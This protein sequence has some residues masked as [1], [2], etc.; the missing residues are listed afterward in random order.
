MRG[1][2]SRPCAPQPTRAH[3]CTPV[4]RCVRPP[5]ARPGCGRWRGFHW[6]VWWGPVQT[7]N[8][9]KSKRRLQSGSGLPGSPLEAPLCASGSAGRGS[10]RKGL[11]GRTREAPGGS[12]QTSHSPL[13][14]SGRA[15]PGRAPCP[16]PPS[17][18]RGEWAPDGERAGQVSGGGGG[19]KAAFGGS[20]KAGP[21]WRAPRERS[22]P[23]LEEPGRPPRSF[24]RSSCRHGPVRPQWP[25]LWVCL[26]PPGW[27]K[28]LGA[29]EGG[30]GPA[31]FCG[32]C[33][34]CPQGAPI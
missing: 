12:T 29:W 7:A 20:V 33:P 32:R 22:A 10:G 15:E 6:R 27:L 26:P 21:G 25:R 18:S 24:L 19:T 9:M 3:L 11:C 23:P 4:V 30:L 8:R 5:L 13:L 1:Q 28:V 17:L 31:Q 2:R 16:P 14:G 34:R